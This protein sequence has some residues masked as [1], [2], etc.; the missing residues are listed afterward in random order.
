[1]AIHPR[2]GQRAQPSDLIDLAALERAYHER[3]PDPANTAERVAFGTSGHRGSPLHGTFVFFASEAERALHRDA[4]LELCLPP[5][6]RLEDGT[7]CRTRH[8]PL[9]YP[10]WV[11]W[12]QPAPY[13]A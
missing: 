7:C 10:V 4:H 12:S 2:A 11:Q 8:G 3:Q 9:R 6:W 5:G 1:M 13:S